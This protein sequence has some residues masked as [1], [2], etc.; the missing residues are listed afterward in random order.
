MCFTVSLNNSSEKILILCRA[1]PAES[2]KYSQTVCVA[3]VTDKNEFRR[4]Y[5]VPFYPLRINGGIPFHKKDWITVNNLKN[6]GDNRKE[7]R[8]IQMNTVNVLNKETDESL[9]NFIQTLVSPSIDSI[10]KSGASLGIIKP[11]IHDYKLKIEST[12]LISNQ[13]Q[14]TGKGISTKSR[15]R[16]GQESKYI[17]T[18]EDKSN[19]LCNKKPHKMILLD[20]EVNELYRNIV[21]GTKDHNEIER[22]MRDK[23]F[24]WMNKDRIVYMMVGT[25]RQ[26][27]TWMAISILY[28]KKNPNK[29]LDAFFS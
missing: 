1:I 7:S 24:N 14:I 28:F 22:K 5:P 8:K 11:S 27:K 2:K 9:H 23:M 18:C 16:L 13:L 25:H 10:K 15:T 20:W 4:L 3:G 17:F 29:K 21:N 6:K 12:S 19:C 26:Y